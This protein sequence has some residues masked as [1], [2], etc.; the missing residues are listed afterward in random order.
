MALDRVYRVL[1]KVNIG[2]ELTLTAP[3]GGSLRV[4]G[5]NDDTLAVTCSDTDALRDMFRLLTEQGPGFSVRNFRYLNNPL[6]QTVTISVGERRL[7]TWAPD[8]LPRVRSLSLLL[9]VLRG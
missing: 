3:S 2:G 4:N 8:S 6:L 5:T 7:L 9:T 1:A